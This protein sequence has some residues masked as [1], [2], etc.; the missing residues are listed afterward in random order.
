M[1]CSS[2]PNFA[3]QLTLQTDVCNQVL[4]AVL[5]KKQEGQEEII[6]YASRAIKNAEKNYSIIE[7]CIAI[8]WDI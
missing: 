5:S 1:L 8:Q 2:H 3:V 7:E 4:G 6:A